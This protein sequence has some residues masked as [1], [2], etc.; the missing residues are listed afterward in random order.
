MALRLGICRDKQLTAEHQLFTS[1]A[2]YADGGICLDILQ[3]QWSPIYDV[4]AILTSI[5][6]S[7]CF[8]YICGAYCDFCLASCSQC[9][10][11]LKRHFGVC[12]HSYVI[13]IQ[14]LRPIL[15]LQSCTVKTGKPHLWHSSHRQSVAFLPLSA[16]C[17]APAG[18]NV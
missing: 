6:V 18:R 12:S 7:L 14:I 1:V 16:L 3:N 8:P 5:Q 17:A 2:V 13:P 9:Y 10:N 15:R 11:P 4:S